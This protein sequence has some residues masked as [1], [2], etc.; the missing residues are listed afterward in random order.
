MLFIIE[1]ILTCQN[2]EN[3]C[4]QNSTFVYIDLCGCEMWYLLLKTFNKLQV[5]E[6]KVLRK[7]S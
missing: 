3:E 1:F 5:F 7:K 4:T 2:T 6:N